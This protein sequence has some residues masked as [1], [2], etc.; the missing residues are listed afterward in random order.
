M[1]T[2]FKILLG[3]GLAVAIVSI[4]Y[5]DDG[6]IT[7]TDEEPS[8]RRD[9]KCAN[10]VLVSIGDCPSRTTASL[11][12]PAVDDAKVISGEQPLR[13]RVENKR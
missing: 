8:I 6:I 5:L 3:S 10:V 4:P 2:L 1:K 9:N 12:V 11:M 7:A 13:F